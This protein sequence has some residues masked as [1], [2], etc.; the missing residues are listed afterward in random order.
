VL[1]ALVEA[2][3]AGESRVLVVHGA[4]GVG[5]TTPG[6]EYTAARR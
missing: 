5:K 4:P 3:R 2:M 1:D 6:L